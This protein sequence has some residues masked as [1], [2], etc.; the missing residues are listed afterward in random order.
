MLTS[1]DRVQIAVRDRDAA[2]ETLRVL[3][4]AKAVRSDEVR[5]LGA[6]RAVVQAGTSEFELLQPSGDG[7]VADFLAER[8]EGLFAAGFAT[9]NL[10]RLCARLEAKGVQVTCEGEQA[11]LARDQTFGMRTVLSPE[12]ERPPVG[13]IRFLYE[14]TNVVGDRQ[15]ATNRYADHFGLDPERFC[16]ITSEQWGYTGTLTMFDP[17]S[18]LDRIEVI[19]T[20]DPTK[21]MGRFHARRGDELYMCYV[22]SDDVDAIAERLEARGGTFW[23]RGERPGLDGLFI[24]PTALHGVLVGV[25]RTTLAWSWS[26]RPDL[27]VGGRAT[28]GH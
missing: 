16:P 26:C 27:V 13:L 14:A 15:V 28:S 23:K 21:A 7:A 1:V 10:D 22:E 4:G 25:S 8:G 11:F 19:Q 17:P 3:L 24:H 6:R 18:K 20:T 5:A 12:R 9:A 2:T